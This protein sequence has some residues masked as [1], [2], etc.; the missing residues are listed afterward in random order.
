MGKIIV[1]E[2]EDVLILLLEE[3]DERVVGYRRANEVGGHLG[4]VGQGGATRFR[5]VG[6]RCGENGGDGFFAE[7]IMERIFPRWHVS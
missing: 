6:D 5:D 4:H 3:N 1:D 2:S 7:A